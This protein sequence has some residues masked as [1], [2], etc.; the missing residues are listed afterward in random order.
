MHDPGSTWLRAP[1]NALLV[2]HSLS[3]R[4]E[5]SLG[6]AV[7]TLPQSPMPSNIGSVWSV[8]GSPTC[9]SHA[10]S[11]DPG[12]N[13]IHVQDRCHG[14]QRRQL[15]TQGSAPPDA[16]LPVNARSSCR[17]RSGQVRSSPATA[18]HSRA[19]LP[20]KRG[21]LGSPAVTMQAP[22]WGTGSLLSITW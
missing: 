22:H 14:P 16:P 15:N 3:H 5:Q 1:E 11:H 21:W 19:W 20:R 18:T 17:S 6:P 8:C 12:P 2:Y 4:Q 9:E 10:A 13:A 7:S